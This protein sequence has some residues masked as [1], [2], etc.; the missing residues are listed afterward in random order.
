MIVF[1]YS[2]QYYARYPKGHPDIITS[3]FKDLSEYF[4]LIKCKVLP[5]RSLLLPCLPYRSNGKLVFALCKR[6][7]DTESQAVCSCTIEERCF[8][9]T[10]TTCELVEAVK[11][12]YDIRKMY[13]VYHFPDSIQY[14]K[15]KGSAGL[16]QAYIQTFL[17]I[18]QEA[19]GYPS[20][21]KTDAD[22]DAYI[23]QFYREQGILL[24]KDS[25]AYK[26]PCKTMP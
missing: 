6:C 26:M 9:G 4:G 16:F 14:S 3:D 25:I 21:V 1:S 19:S 5:P 8:I 15:E 7:T 23:D 22:K 12:G 20:W 10:W 17:K 13:E 2:T 11:H 18:K 24:E